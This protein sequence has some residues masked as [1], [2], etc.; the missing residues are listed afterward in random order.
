MGGV[1]DLFPPIVHNFLG[2]MCLH[3]HFVS[4]TNNNLTVIMSIVISCH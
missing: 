2:Q 3:C 4:K 1:V